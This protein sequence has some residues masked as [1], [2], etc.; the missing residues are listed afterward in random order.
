[1]NGTNKN[2][3]KYMK[4]NNLISVFCLQ[5]QVFSDSLQQQHSP[6]PLV[7]LPP[8]PSELQV[9][10]ERLINVNAPHLLL[11]SPSLLLL[12]PHSVQTPSLSARVGSTAPKLHQ[13]HHHHPHHLL[14]LLLHTSWSSG[15]APSDASDLRRPH[16]TQR[17]P[18]LRLQRLSGQS[19]NPLSELQRK[20]RVG[21]PSRGRFPRVG[22]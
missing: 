16:P 10:R 20:P 21:A 7:L 5:S 1:M 18:I 6:R 9:F 8:P 12:L 11:H 14:L 17:R 2:E 19:P 4:I 13:P 15:S 3:M 22:S